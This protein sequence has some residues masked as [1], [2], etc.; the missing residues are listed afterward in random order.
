MLTVNLHVLMSI[1]GVLIWAVVCCVLIMLIALQ[2]LH[3]PL[4]STFSMYKKFRTKYL[5]S[6]H[7]NKAYE[8]NIVSIAWILTSK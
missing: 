3:L 8:I 2:V 7:K 5:L 4:L 6:T 1:S